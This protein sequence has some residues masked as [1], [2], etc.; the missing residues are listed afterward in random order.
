MAQNPYL[1]HEEDL[2]ANQGIDARADFIV[3]TYMHLLGAIIAFAGVIAIFMKIGVADKISEMLGQ[4]YLFLGLIL[5]IGVI[6]H[7]TER[8]ALQTRSLSKQ[9]AALSVYIVIEALLF[10][11]LI[12]YIVNW[13]NLPNVITISAVATIGIF[14]ALTAIMFYTRKDLSH[15]GRYL[16]FAGVGAIAMIIVIAL[17]GISLG[18]IFSVLLIF[19]AAGYILYDTSNVIH[20]YHTD[21][22][23]GA[24]IALFA[25]LAMLFWHI[26]LLVL[27]F[28]GSD[29]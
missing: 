14:S 18:P 23:V 29:D 22:Y 10:S 21:Q 15:W 20:H 26:I 13:L 5:V 16:M 8:V 28:S 6:T 11:G 19:L 24:S 1:I 17:F 27:R 4:G 9:Y 7:F 2:V 3:K 12:N 25:S